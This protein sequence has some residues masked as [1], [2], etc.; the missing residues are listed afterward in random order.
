MTKLPKSHLVNGGHTLNKT[1]L[2]DG[3]EVGDNGVVRL[4]PL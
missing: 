1:N 4:T 2:G 3:A